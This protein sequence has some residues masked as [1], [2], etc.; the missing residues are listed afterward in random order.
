MKPAALLLTVAATLSCAVPVVARE[1]VLAEHRTIPWDATREEIPACRAP[2]VL[3]KIAQQFR[4]RESEYWASSLRIVVMDN[5]RAIAFR[6]NGLDYIP[7]RHCT[8]RGHFTDGRQ[9]GVVY[10]VIEGG[11]LVG[12]S[13]G[14]EWC[15]QGLDRH[16]AY[17]PHCHTAR[18]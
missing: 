16:M 3:E 13:D 15:V 11:S 10:S 17:A 4:A 2:E 9:R 14:V 12:V 1:Q 6:A 18:P 8:A 7:R 5:I